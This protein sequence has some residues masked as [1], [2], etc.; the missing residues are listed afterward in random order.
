MKHSQ[1]NR[2]L[3]NNDLATVILAAGKSSRFG[4]PKA[5]APW[6]N[7]TVLNHIIKVIQST[8]IAEIIVV[9][10]G[11]HEK[12]ES[13]IDK[14]VVKIVFNSEFENGSM[15][16]SLQKGLKFIS[17]SAPAIMIFLGDQPRISSKTISLL[18]QEFLSSKKSIVVPVFR[19]HKGH[20]WILGR[21]YWKE[22][23]SLTEK[24]T[25]QHF[26][27]H[28][29][30]ELQNVIIESGEILDDFDTKEDFL[31]LIQQKH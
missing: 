10:G 31:K 8:G 23:A 12:V 28:H 15:V 13:S 14:G 20:P 7:T 2:N 11:D 21:K 16:V 3:I 27:N 22:I 26:L 24:D 29:E 30:N 4:E 1:N 9:T 19:N 5:L 6:E 18:R 25:L 17:S